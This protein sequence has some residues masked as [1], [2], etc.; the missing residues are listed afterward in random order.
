MYTMKEVCKETNLSYETLKYYCNEGL[1]PNVKRN[2]NNHRVFDDDNIFWI[3]N[4]TCLKKCGMGIAE[5]K[6]YVRLYLEGEDSIEQRKLILSRKKEQLEEK[7]R[8][9]Q[10]S[11]AY[12]NSKQELYDK[13]LME[14]DR[15][16]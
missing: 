4:L 12:I 15:A 16:L 14:K 11:I 7:L 13:L 10:E 8:E 9:I 6:E 1:I 2:G 5:M 3:K